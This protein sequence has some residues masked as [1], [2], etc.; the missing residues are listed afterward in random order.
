MISAWINTSSALGL[1]GT[2]TCCSCSLRIYSCWKFGFSLKKTPI[3]TLPQAKVL[4]LA[5]FTERKEAIRT[6]IK[7]VNYTIKRNY[8][9]YMSHRKK[10]VAYWNERCHPS[11]MIN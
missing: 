5:A 9:A 10:R 8:Y 6:A 11:K 7:K 3:L 4:V 1:R 2:D